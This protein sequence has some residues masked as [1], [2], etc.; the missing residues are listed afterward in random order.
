MKKFK[1][2]FL[3]AV[4]VLFTAC[5]TVDNRIER[6]DMWEYM[7][8]STNYRVEY[9]VYHNGSKEDYHNIEN[10]IMYSDRYEQESNGGIT[11]FTVNS[12]HIFMLEPDQEVTV[13]RY[14]YLGDSNIFRGKFIQTCSLEQFY[15]NYEVK[16]ILFH[17]VLRVDCTSASGVKQEFYYGYNEG[18]VAKYINDGY[19][20]TVWVK[21][22]ESRI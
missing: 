22:Y 4:I 10:H 8:S 13:E 16:G 5:G 7:T 21:F 2:L 20:E 14:V 15:K 3:S 11:T 1:L 18:L 6:F 19:D 17:N 9:E 12:S